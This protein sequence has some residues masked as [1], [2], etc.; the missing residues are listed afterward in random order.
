M[1]IK[2]KSIAKILPLHV[3]VEEK[4]TGFRAHCLDFD[5]AVSGANQEQ[6]MV[7]LEKIIKAHLDYAVVHK[8]NPVHL[9]SPEINQKWFDKSTASPLKKS[10]ILELH[11]SAPQRKGGISRSSFKRK[12][13][14][15]FDQLVCA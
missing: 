8:S 6:S 13:R 11:I 3:L 4:T 14:Q 10:Y 7:R 5:L 12:T 15:N 1:R 2:K 9:A